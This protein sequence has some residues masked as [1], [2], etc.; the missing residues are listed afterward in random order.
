MLIT[1]EARP[2]SS[3]ARRLLRQAAGMVVDPEL[4]EELEKVVE[5]EK[6]VHRRAPQVTSAKAD[7][8]RTQT[9]LKPNAGA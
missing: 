8:T 3:Q 6:G 1:S 2:T 5:E 4:L 7:P 9:G